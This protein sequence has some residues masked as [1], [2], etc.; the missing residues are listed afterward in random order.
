MQVYSNHLVQRLEFSKNDAEAVRYVSERVVSLAERHGLSLRSL[1]RI[2]AY[3][4]MCFAFTGQ[5]FYRPS[6]MIADLCY[7]KLLNSS[8]FEKLKVGKATYDEV[9]VFLRLPTLNQM[10]ASKGKDADWI[11]RFWYFCLAAG[12]PPI[13]DFSRF[14]PAQYGIYEKEAVIPTLINAVLDRLSK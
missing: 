7:I 4:A 1:E 3:I 8:L 6:S 11:E 10:V 14:V 9:A 5:N 2:F 12:S 13:D